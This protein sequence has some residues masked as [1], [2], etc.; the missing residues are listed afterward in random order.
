MAWLLL[1]VGGVSAAAYVCNVM[2]EVYTDTMKPLFDYIDEYKKENQ[3]KEQ[4]TNKY[5]LIDNVKERK[6][7][8]QAIADKYNINISN[9]IIHNDERVCTIIFISTERTKN[10]TEAI[11]LAK[12]DE[13]RWVKKYKSII[14]QPYTTL[15]LLKM[16]IESFHI[17]VKHDRYDVITDFKSHIDMKD[18]L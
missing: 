17:V 11:E 8:R 16:E 10:K 7:K 4:E 12:E 2:S 5:A 15:E 9:V 14:L 1:G 3:L 13:E 6:T 18:F